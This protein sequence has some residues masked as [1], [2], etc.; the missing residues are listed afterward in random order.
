MPAICVGCRA[1]SGD[2][3]IR[4][5]AADAVVVDTVDAAVEGV[6]LGVDVG[7]G[8][9]VGVAVTVNGLGSVDVGSG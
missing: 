5:A 7:V 6:G 9:I 3:T 1:E 2:A 8:A 4:D